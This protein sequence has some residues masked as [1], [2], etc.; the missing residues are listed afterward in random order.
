MRTGSL[1]FENSK[2]TVK[3]RGRS[4]WVFLSLL[5]L[6]T[7]P[8]MLCTKDDIVLSMVLQSASESRP[9]EFWKGFH[10]AL[11]RLEGNANL[12]PED[13]KGFYEYG[14]LCLKGLH[15]GSQARAAFERALALKP[16]FAEAY[17]G[18][19]WAYLDTW[20]IDSALLTRAAKPNF[21]EAK[22]NF[23]LAIKFNPDYSDSYIGLG[24]TYGQMGLNAEALAF[25]KRAIEIDS[26]NPEAWDLLSRTREALGQYEESIEAQLQTMRFRSQE[27]G[28]T[29]L[30]Y[31]HYLPPR[32]S[33]SYLR[34]IELGRL[35][36]K[37][38]HYDEAIGSY[39][40]AIQMEPIEPEGYHHLGLAYYLKG[41]KKSAFAQYTALRT[42]CRKADPDSG[43]DGFTRDLFD[44]IEK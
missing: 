22:R 24:Y 23:R 8:S 27:T 25:I 32:E 5:L 21:E 41:D 29:A 33:D 17:N 39:K 10:E 26:H 6:F 1:K 28:E 13:A 36:E 40:Q 11:V 43:C 3:R 12:H 30:T 16:D 42:I 35:Y 19:G 2:R 31:H 9:P 34:L 18:L 7:S 20:G 38:S 44:R 4:T 15:T 14:N 37:I